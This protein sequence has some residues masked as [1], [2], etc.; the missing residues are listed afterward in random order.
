MEFARLHNFVRIIV[1]NVLVLRNVL[2]AKAATKVLMG[3]V[4]LNA[5]FS[6]VLN[7][8][9]QLVVSNA[10]KHLFCQTTEINVNVLQPTTFSMINVPV[11]KIIQNLLANAIYVMLPI[12]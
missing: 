2:N 1:R 9:T 5:I 10:T 8:L 11:L 3:N 7:V 4:C 6:T 12:V